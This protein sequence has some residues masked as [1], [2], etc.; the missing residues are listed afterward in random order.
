MHFQLGKRAAA[1]NGPGNLQQVQFAS[2]G[3]LNDFFVVEWNQPFFFEISLII[4][5]WNQPFFFAPR[6]LLPSPGP[7]AN[8]PVHL[9]HM[10]SR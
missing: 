4:S 5:E 9:S 8:A 7:N 1:W 10:V 2:S 3:F 6:C